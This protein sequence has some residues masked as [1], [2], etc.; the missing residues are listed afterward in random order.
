MATKKKAVKKTAKKVKKPVILPMKMSSLIKIGLADIRKAEKSEK[1]LVDMGHWY[2]VEEVK[3]YLGDE[4]GNDPISTTDT[5]VVCAGGSVMAF[6]LGAL[7]DKSKCHLVPASFPDNHR[8]LEA[9][10]YLRQGDSYH[11]A[12]YLRL[13]DWDAP[14]GD[15]QIKKLLKLNTHIPEYSRENPE[16]FH[17]A[18]EKYRL[19]LIKAGF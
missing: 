15:K 3:C 16:P 9:L 1:C 13:V 7:E 17:K 6:S 18:M 10:D 4:A 12:R 19:K 11:A 5:C 14:F 8:Q 2:D